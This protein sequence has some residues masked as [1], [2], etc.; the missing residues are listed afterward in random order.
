[1]KTFIEQKVDL[2]TQIE[3]LELQNQQLYDEIDDNELAIAKL[4]KLLSEVGT[5][6]EELPKEKDEIRL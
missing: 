6:S 2:R 5:S 4:Q 3:D 1:M